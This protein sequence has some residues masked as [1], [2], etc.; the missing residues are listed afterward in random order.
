MEQ[1]TGFWT[2]YL[3]CFCMFIVGIAILLAGK[4]QYIVR[5]PR[6]S[7][8]P[9]AFKAM[10]IG[11]KNKG[12]MG[13]LADILRPSVMFHTLTFCRRCK[14]FVPRGVWTQIQDTLERS[15]HR[16]AQAWTYR[17]PSLCLLSDLLGSV[18]SDVEQFRFSRY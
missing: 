18:L 12:N 3:L 4:K 7:V 13:T 10:W 17:L 1:R 11:L 6:G 16:R 8:I 5:P 2:A 15:F 9:N 14:T